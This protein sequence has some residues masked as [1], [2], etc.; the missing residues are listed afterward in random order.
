MDLIILVTGKFV[1]DWDIDYIKN[2]PLSFDAI[3]NYLFNKRKKICFIK[4]FERN[5]IINKEIF[6]IFILF[7]SLQG[8][9]WGKS[10]LLW[11][12]VF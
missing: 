7:N 3:I 9:G 2:F 6:D 10:F 4:V 12:Q 5:L 1:F 11:V 8:W